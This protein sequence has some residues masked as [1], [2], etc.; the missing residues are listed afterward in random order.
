MQNSSHDHPENSY[1]PA[2]F[3]PLFKAEEKHFWFTARNKVIG[4]ITANLLKGRKGPSRILEIGC[5]TGNVLREWVKLEPSPDLVCGMDLFSEG[6]LIANKRVSCSFVQADLESPPFR[7]S[8]NLIG[9]FD[10]LEHIPDDQGVLDSLGAML[11]EDG[12][13]LITVPAFPS[14]WSYFDVASHHVQRYK[15]ED[16][17]AKVTA[18]G[19]SVEFISYYMMTIFPVV[20]LQRKLA[21]SNQLNQADDNPDAVRSLALN[22]LKIIPVLNGVLKF[23]LSLEAKWIQRFHKLPFGTSIVVVARK[24]KVYG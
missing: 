23:I 22:E 4:S 2:Y 21:G 15:V 10:V 11:A 13:V 12:S 20:W 3:E 6:L 18:A 14:L 5:G 7:R 1:D 16:L 8:F 17:R 19:F 9:L 24:N